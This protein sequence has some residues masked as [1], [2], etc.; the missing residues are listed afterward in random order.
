M[1][2]LYVYAD[3]AAFL[4]GTEEILGTG[5]LISE[6][7]IDQTVVTTAMK[8]LFDDQE[9]DKKMDQRTIDNGYFHAS[10]DSKNGHSHFCRGIVGNIS[11]NFVYS[12]LS[13][14]NRSNRSAESLF[15]LT[16]KLV[17]G[18]F[19][20][21]PCDVEMIVEGRMGFGQHNVNQFLAEFHKEYALLADNLPSIINIFSKISITIA[22]KTH[23]G[24]QVVDFIL[25]A[26]NRTMMTP[27][28]N[29]WR[30]RLTLKLREFLSTEDA[31]QSSGHYY[32]KKPLL[33]YTHLDDSRISYPYPVP[34]EIPKSADLLDYYD[35]IEN[36]LAHYSTA[37]LPLHCLHWQEAIQQS[38]AMITNGK[39]DESALKFICYTFIYIF[40]TLPIYGEFSDDDQE[41]WLDILFAKRLAGIVIGNGRIHHGRTRDA[42]LRWKWAQQ[43]PYHNL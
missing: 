36:T 2:K 5:I 39:F 11:G 42:I 41:A 13:K 18:K 17:C 15:R 35:F 7:P 4:R 19:M 37:V 31:D 30:D 8:L 16:L 3:E 33:D 34:K 38:N 43:K 40:D 9:F 6:T 29:V 10:E 28:N 32:L 23:P 14:T 1:K 24:L 20:D 25:W 12:Y 26:M 21:E 22:D 27:G